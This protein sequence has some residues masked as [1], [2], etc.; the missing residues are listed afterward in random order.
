GR[1][2]MPGLCIGLSRTPGQV[3]APAPRL[4]EHDATAGRW[5][6]R[7]GAPPP[8]PGDGGA[9]TLRRD[10]P[11]PAGRGPLAGYRVL[12]LGTILA[13]PHAGPLL[14]RLRAGGGK[15][16]A[17]GGGGVPGASLGANR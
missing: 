15:G 1:V 9:D 8:T 7:S 17:P 10:G 2:V 3:R 14:A 6:R 16:E 13:G 11:G 4:G 12:D 5:A